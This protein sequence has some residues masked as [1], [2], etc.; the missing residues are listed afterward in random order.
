VRTLVRGG[1][2]VG[3]ERGTHTLRRDG[4]VVLEDD[5][6]LQVGPPFD[7]HVDRQ[8]DARGKPVSPWTRRKGARR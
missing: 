3:F 5:R 4:V 1:W 6:V 8:I 7:G 2:V